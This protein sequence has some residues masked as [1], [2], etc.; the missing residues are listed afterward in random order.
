MDKGLLMF[1]SFVL[2]LKDTIKQ[3][4]HFFDQQR[5]RLFFLEREQG[6]SVFHDARLD[7]VPRLV[8]RKRTHYHRLLLKRN[9]FIE[10][11]VVINTWHGPVTVG[12][13]TSVG[14]GS[15]LIGPIEVGANTSIAQYGFVSGENR[16]QG[17]PGE[18]LKPASE[19]VEI[20]PV[21][22]GNGVWVGA[23]VKIMPGCTIGDGSIVAA[24]S[25]VT[26]DI[27]PNS[28]A[29]GVPAVIKKDLSAGNVG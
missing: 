16:I 18:G 23:G 6:S 2:Y 5:A 12:E 10:S 14:I 9:A 17:A 28:L 3:V 29:A 4:A 15:I 22:I 7:I 20:K 26:R 1:N 27:P 24:G 25:V 21:K 8:E 19:S 11:R 13:N